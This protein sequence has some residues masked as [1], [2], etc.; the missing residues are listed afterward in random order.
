MQIFLFKILDQLSS[1]SQRKVAAELEKIAI[2]LV[3]VATNQ[4]K[5]LDDCHAERISRRTCFVEVFPDLRPG[6]ATTFCLRGSKF[7]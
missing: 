4:E 1:V 3:K 6:S 2:E 5:C 7:L